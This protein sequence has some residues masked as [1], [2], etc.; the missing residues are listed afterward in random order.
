MVIT[1]QEAKTKRCQEA[2]PA[3]SQVTIGGM[4]YAAPMHGGAYAVVTAPQNCLGGACMA[5]Q[6]S[7]IWAENYELVQERTLDGIALGYCGKAHR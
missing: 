4:A 3:C 6:W 1:E 7:K 5:W 2:F